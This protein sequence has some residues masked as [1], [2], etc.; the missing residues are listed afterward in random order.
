MKKVFSLFSLAVLS[1][2][3]LAGCSKFDNDDNGNNAAAG[4]MAFNLATDQS[5]VGTSIGGNY[6]TSVPLGYSHYTGG[7]LAV[8]P[9]SRTVE[10]SDVSSAARLAAASF[11]FEN[12]KYYSTFLVGADGNY[13]QLI[14]KDSID[15]LPGTG[16]A[17]VRFINAIPDS[18]VSQVRLAVNGANRLEES[19][20]YTQ[21]SSFTAMSP[22]ELAVNIS[23]GTDIDA[24]RTIT[25]EARKIYTLLL[26]GTP[27][28]TAN[29]VEIKFVQNGTTEAEQNGGRM[30]AAVRVKTAE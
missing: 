22:G 10:S 3:I 5:Q 25:I 8:F 30:A 20:R 4:L 2:V 7:Y 11:D 27:G 26:I 15:S 9:G 14:V 23:N 19:S 24:S 21:I 17:Y 1:G 6:I 28:A 12:Q 29:G 16:E 13:Q 18:S